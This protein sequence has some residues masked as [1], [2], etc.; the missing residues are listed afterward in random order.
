VHIERAGDISLQYQY[1]AGTHPF[2]KK[3]TR[4]HMSLQSVFRSS[5]NRETGRKQ[6]TFSIKSKNN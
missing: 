6:L 1:L 4:H 2:F 3:I 5:T